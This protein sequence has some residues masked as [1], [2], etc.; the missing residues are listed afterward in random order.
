MRRT[1][2]ISAVCCLVFGVA[3]LR[4]DDKDLRAVI[5]K[6]I[7]A[8]GGAEALAKLPASTWK[9]KGKAHVLGQEIDFTGEWAIQPPGQSRVIFE[10]EFAGQKIQR[11]QVVNG[12]KGW[13]KLNESLEEM[14]KEAL[15]EAKE[16]AHVGQVINLLVLADKAY[17]LSSL[18]EAKVN[19]RN[20]IGIKVAHK[21]HRD[22]NVYFDKEN[23]L[24]VK[25]ATRIKDVQSGMEFNQETV[26]DDYKEVQGV[27]QPMKVTIKRDN[28]PFVEAANSDF[29]LHEKLADNLFNKP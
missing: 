8:R 23:G 21:S 2:V 7:K 5:D 25:T 26:H 16:A 4:G 22:V 6:A 13:V 3:P 28:A 11:I 14:D 9:A 20:A 12:D 24:L 19:G 1:W 27:K 10:F 18:G 17:Q 15:T 29:K